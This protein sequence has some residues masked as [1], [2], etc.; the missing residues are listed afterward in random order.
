[1]TFYFGAPTIRILVKF[2]GPR[3]FPDSKDPNEI[4]IARTI[5]ADADTGTITGSKSVN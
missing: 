4:R 3:F 5:F 2:T 1:M